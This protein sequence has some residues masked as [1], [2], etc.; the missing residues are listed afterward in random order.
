MIRR[1][2][3]STLFPY[4]TLFRSLASSVE[5]G[6]AKSQQHGSLVRSEAVGLFEGAYG[7]VRLSALQTDPGQA[8]LRQGQ[9][10]LYGSVGR[11][12]RGRLG[13]LR[14]RRAKAP[15]IVQGHP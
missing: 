9:I 1:P 3:R 2:P 4:T 15:G 11:I 14:Q 12:R 13:E 5:M 8:R 6:G 10:A 7:L